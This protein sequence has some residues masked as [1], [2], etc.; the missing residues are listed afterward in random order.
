MQDKLDANELALWSRFLSELTGI[1][2]NKDKEYLIRERLQG[3]LKKYNCSS[4]SHL[5]FLAQEPERRDLREELIDQIT[6]KETSFF[7]D[8][9]PF[10]AMRKVIFPRLLE[11][12]R[13]SGVK[14]KLKIW[15]AACSTGQ[16]AYS[17]AMILHEMGVPP[18]DFHITATDISRMA[19]DAAKIGTYNSF[20]VERGIPQP[21]LERF[22]LP[23]SKNWQVKGFL[24]ESLNFQ[25]MS[26]HRPFLFSERFDLVVCRNVAIY[27]T[28]KPR[29]E[30][31]WNISRHLHPEGYLL[32]GSTE[33]VG[34]LG[35]L[36]REIR[37]EARAVFLQTN[38]ETTPEK[39]R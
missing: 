38:E 4:F 14:R 39:V 5:Y 9:A 35:K 36:F 23:V 16:E 32:I 20:E 11:Q 24:K 21:L 17:I 10:E 3:L 18:Q 8:S 26:L 1:S 29:E 6:T 15:S 30:L 28:P 19:V 33:T 12:C 25:Q 37:L 13:K 22:F 27:F 7:R 2:L 34:D 31:F